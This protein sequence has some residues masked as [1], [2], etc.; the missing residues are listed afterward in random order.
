M[1]SSD[2]LIKAAANRIR[3]RFQKNMLD[4]AASMANTAID[5]PEKIKTEWNLLKEE[6]IEEAAKIKRQENS[7]NKNKNSTN[8]N[9]RINLIREKLSVLTRKVE[10]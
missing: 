7:N 2:T 3:A 9:Q 8:T 1:D 5:A 4:A 10:E 6:I